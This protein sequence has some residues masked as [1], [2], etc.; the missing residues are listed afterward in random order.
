MF[1]TTKRIPIGRVSGLLATLSLLAAPA[2]ADETYVVDPMAGNGSG[3]LFRVDAAN[4]NR[5]LVSDFGN[6][7]QGPLG[8][9]PLGIA[10]EA[11][12]TVLIIDLGTGT[13]VIPRDAADTVLVSDP[14]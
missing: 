1:K 8:V 9:N 3:A 10:L 5:T 4:G 11:A 6:A 13:I 14:D 12:G 2:V 7:A